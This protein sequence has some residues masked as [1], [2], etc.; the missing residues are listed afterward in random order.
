MNTNGLATTGSIGGAHGRIDKEQSME[1]AERHASPL[2]L[3]AGFL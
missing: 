3:V 2:R 1:E